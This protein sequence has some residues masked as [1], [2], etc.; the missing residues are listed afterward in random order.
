MATIENLI[1]VTLY[2]GYTVAFVSYKNYL[3]KELVKGNNTSGNRQFDHC[4][5]GRG[6]IV[7]GT[8]EKRDLVFGHIC[9]KLPVR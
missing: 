6:I 8:Q 4:G 2:V 9:S 3:D 7:D 1:S 5:A